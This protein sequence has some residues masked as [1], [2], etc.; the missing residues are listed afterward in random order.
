M[1][2]FQRI[3]TVSASLKQKLHTFTNLPCHEHVI[4]EMG[5]GMI[6]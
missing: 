2:K 4:A 1:L 5:S 3:I 6:L